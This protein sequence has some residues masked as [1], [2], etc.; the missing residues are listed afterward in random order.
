[1]GL[2]QMFIIAKK[3]GSRVGVQREYNAFS[4]QKMCLL[5]YVALTYASLYQC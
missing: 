1:M 3:E 4:N 2:Y 5:L